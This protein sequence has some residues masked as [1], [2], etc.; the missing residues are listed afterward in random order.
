MPWYNHVTTVNNAVNLRFTKDNRIS[1]IYRLIYALSWT[2]HFIYLHITTGHQ[3]KETEIYSW[4]KFAFLTKW[5]E[6]LCVVYS[7]FSFLSVLKRDSIKIHKISSILQTSATGLAI[8]ITFMYIFIL[9]DLRKY[10]I[11]YN[12]YRDIYWHQMNTYLSVIDLFLTSNGVFIEALFFLQVFGVV[13]G[14]V[15]WLVWFKTGLLV[16]PNIGWEGEKLKMSI[17]L[18]IFM[19]LLGLPILYLV[20]L[21]LAKF[22]DWI[23][24]KLIKTDETENPDELENFK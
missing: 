12:T 21:G 16:Y 20:V 1:V 10:W 3:R 6:I 24:A 4:W 5:G 14:F 13:Y 18:F 22:R 2:I 7:I 23:Y 15:N 17:G 8:G 11:Y 9:G 19:V